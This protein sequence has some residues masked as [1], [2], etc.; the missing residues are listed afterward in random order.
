MNLFNKKFAKELSQ[1]GGITLDRDSFA[2]YFRSSN[3]KQLWVDKLSYIFNHS[4]GTKEKKTKFRV[5]RDHG[6]VYA[7]WM[8][9]FLGQEQAMKRSWEM[10]WRPFSGSLMSY[11]TS[12]RNCQ[13]G[14]RLANT[15]QCWKPR[16]LSHDAL[17]QE[18]KR[19]CEAHGGSQ[20]EC[21]GHHGQA[22]VLEPVHQSQGSQFIRPEEESRRVRL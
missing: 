14:G 20:Q 4:D 6:N 1:I 2:D 19:R 15:D 11:P 16:D 17:Q 12:E 9:W 18:E 21:Q 10:D 3:G 22:G 5:W 8:R 7:S 13:N